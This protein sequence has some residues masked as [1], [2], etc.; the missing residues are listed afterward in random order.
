MR[1]PV[2]T[3]NACAS[4]GRR[5]LRIGH[6]GAAALEAANSLASLETALAFELD[7]IEIDVLP[8][9]EGLVLAHGQPD[10][11]AAPGLDE[12]LALL[13]SAPAQPGVLV[14]LKARGYERALVEALV[15][16][17]L[18]ERALVASCFSSSLRLIAEAEPAIATGLSY[19]LDR[20][21]L[22]ER[23]IGRV[24]TPLGLTCLRRALP[25]RLARLLARAPVRAALLQVGVLSRRAVEICH[26]HGIAVL[27]WTVDDLPCLERVLELGADGVISNDPRIFRV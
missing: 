5:Y 9:G 25:F 22:S 24:L 4:L 26:G 19:P 17:G 6:R 21:S 27:A 12:A 7:L 18:V 20:Y 14:D 3:S 1:C 15:R 8:R 2:S 16:H 23:Q 11:D 13:A 10:L